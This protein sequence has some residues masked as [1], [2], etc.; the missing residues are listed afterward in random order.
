MQNP[1]ASRYQTADGWSR[2]YPKASAIWLD[3]VGPGTLV[4]DNY[5]T[6]VGPAVLPE[7]TNPSLPTSG[8]T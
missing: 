1:V 3:A 8:Y 6:D 5:F 4:A 2:P 7:V